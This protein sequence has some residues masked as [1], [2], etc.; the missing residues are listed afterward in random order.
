MNTTYQTQNFQ[1]V[2]TNK[3]GVG[4]GKK[5][6]ETAQKSVSYLRKKKAT[7]TSEKALAKMI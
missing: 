5:Y 1:F 7:L 3:G 4:W 2:K 6:I